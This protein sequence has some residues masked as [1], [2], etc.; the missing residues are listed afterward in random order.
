M[1]DKPVPPETSSEIARNVGDVPRTIT[2]SLEK[3]VTRKTID[4][5]FERVYN[6]AGCRN[7]GLMG[8]DIHLQVVDPAIRSEFKG[9]EGV[10]DVS[11]AAS[12]R[13]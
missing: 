12:L 6:L 1:A 3:G 4:A 7:C 10:V 8:F 11:A 13:G 5:L 2:F 9:I